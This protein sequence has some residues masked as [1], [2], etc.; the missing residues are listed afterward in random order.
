MKPAFA[1]RR[2]P[3]AI[4]RLSPFDDRSRI[5]NPA[6][7]VGQ[8]KATRT[9]LSMRLQKRG[10]RTMATPTGHT[11]QTCQ[12]S[13]DY[14]ADCTDRTSIPLARGNTFPPCGKCH[15]AVTWTLYRYA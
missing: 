5:I 15:R 11:G 14:R 2:A 13:G 9:L 12:T 8:A 1:K 4:E 3:F 6:S 7:K 10:S